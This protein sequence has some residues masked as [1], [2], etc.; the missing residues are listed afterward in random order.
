[1]CMQGVMLSKING[2][3][4]VRCLTEAVLL[5][6][7]DCDVRISG[8]LSCL[9]KGLTMVFLNSLP[10]VACPSGMGCGTTVRMPASQFVP[11]V[12]R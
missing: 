4:V 1:M 3:N 5:T 10:G 2:N 11:R 9:L 8:K 6:R 12:D 7:V